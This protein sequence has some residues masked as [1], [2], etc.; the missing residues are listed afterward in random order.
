MRVLGGKVRDSH[1]QY[2][3]RLLFHVYIP[4][5]KC[6]WKG[7]LLS[8]TELLS[9]FSRGMTSLDVHLENELAMLK[10][11]LVRGNGGEKPVCNCRQF[12]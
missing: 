8:S 3:V 1:E 12:G 7:L 6:F 10:G 9:I 11:R 2:S 4:E 5:K